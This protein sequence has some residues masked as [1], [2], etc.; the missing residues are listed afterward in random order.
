MIYDSEDE[1]KQSVLNFCRFTVVSHL[2]NIEKMI[3]SLKSFP[4][5]KKACLSK[6]QV[7]VYVCIMY[8]YIY[9]TFIC[10]KINS[11][12]ATMFVERWL[13]SYNC[14]FYQ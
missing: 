6:E 11:A 7:Y 13:K 4:S 14:T 3:S 9:N 8:V 12:H 5:S 10:Y 2:M 1:E